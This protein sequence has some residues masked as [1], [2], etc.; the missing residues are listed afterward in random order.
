M[1][2]SIRLRRAAQ[3]EYDNA[4]DWYEA[5]GRGLGLRFVAAIQQK[6]QTISGQP[7]RYPEVWPGVRE[8]LVSGWPYCIYYQVHS[9]HVMVLA[10][11]HTSRDPSVWQSRA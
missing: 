3:S 11:F 8:A 4:A 5:R 6:L 9:D 2:L 10:V 7:D 1:S